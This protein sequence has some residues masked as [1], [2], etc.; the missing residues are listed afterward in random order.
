MLHRFAA[1]ETWLDAAL[2][3]APAKRVKGA[4]GLQDQPPQPGRSV[5]AFLKTN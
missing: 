5:D 3:E 1:L 2:A 4:K